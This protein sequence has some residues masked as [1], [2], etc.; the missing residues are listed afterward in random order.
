M[1][2]YVLLPLTMTAAI[3]VDGIVKQFGDFT[4]VNG[5][6]FSRRRRARSSAC[7]A[8]TAPASRR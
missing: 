8:R 1:T 7:S 2:A 4:A 6:S 5:I 3:D